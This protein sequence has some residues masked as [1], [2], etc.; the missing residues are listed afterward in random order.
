MARQRDIIQQMSDKELGKQLILSQMLLFILSFVLSLFFFDHVAQWLD[1]FQLDM[2]EVVW[3]GV[4]PGLVIVLCDLLLMYIFPKRYYDDGGI[5]NKIFQNR[6]IGSI[7]LIVLLVAVSEELLFRGVLQTT[8]G[9]ILA[10]SIFALVHIRYI[11]KPVLL[12]SVLF[13]SFYI[14]YMFEL[15][16]NLFTTITAH[17]IVDFLLGLIIRFQK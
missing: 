15:T 7:F 9:F 1:Y 13:V 5:N 11:T 12:V 8:F 6:S 4:I 16:G 10:S 14:G 17:F 2:R 3:Y